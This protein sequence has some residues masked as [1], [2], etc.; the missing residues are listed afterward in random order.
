[1]VK[2]D[3][4]KCKTMKIHI[5]QLSHAIEEAEDRLFEYAETRMHRQVLPEQLLEEEHI[6]LRLPNESTEDS[7][8]IE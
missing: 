2:P 7:D 1:M 3:P 6:Y 5:C 8:L 4:L